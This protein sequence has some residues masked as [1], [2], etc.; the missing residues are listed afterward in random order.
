MYNFQ[1]MKTP[2]QNGQHKSGLQPQ[3][4]GPWPSA[5]MAVA[6]ILFGERYSSDRLFFMSRVITL[7]AIAL[8]ISIIGNL[9]LLP[10][11]PRYRYIPI[12]TS[13]L[14]LP[15]VPLNQA[16]HDD[17]FVIDWTIDAVTRLYSFDFMN[18]RAQL[19]DARKNLTERGFENFQASMKESNNWTSIMRNNFVLTAVPTGAGRIVDK[20]LV[21][22]NFTWTVQFPMLVSYRSSAPMKNGNKAEDRILSDAMNMTITVTRV[23]VFLN[24]TGLGI[25]YIVG[26]R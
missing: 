10:N 14:V 21:N 2:V 5:N 25:K 11:P 18:Y 13:G 15:Q 3:K 6:M 8:I 9:A 20:G 22:G 26:R 23:G 17:Q 12:S 19:Q 4:K 16:N 1:K 7:L 24:H